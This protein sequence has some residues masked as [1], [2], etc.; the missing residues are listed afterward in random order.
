MRYLALFLNI[1]W[2]AGVISGFRWMLG[3]NAFDYGVYGLVFVTLIIN[4]YY[5]WTRK[6]EQIEVKEH[7]EA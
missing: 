4:I 7:K 5:I 1:L 3:S 6:D 2:L